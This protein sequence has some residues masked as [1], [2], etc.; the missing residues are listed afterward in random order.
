MSKSN[1]NKGGSVTFKVTPKIENEREQ[2]I[3]LQMKK[4]ILE[5][6]YCNIN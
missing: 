2:V 4:K 6:K 5:E 3:E 1:K